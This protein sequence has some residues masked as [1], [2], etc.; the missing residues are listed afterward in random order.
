[1]ADQKT[2]IEAFKL[3][4]DEAEMLTSYRLL[5]PQERIH[6]RTKLAEHVRGRAQAIEKRQREAGMVADPPIGTRARE[7]A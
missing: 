2:R 5:T 6:A 7:G 4:I 3:R 1:M